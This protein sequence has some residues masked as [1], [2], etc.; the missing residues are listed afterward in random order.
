M[1]ASLESKFKIILNC[2]QKD[3][4]SQFFPHTSLGFH[5]LYVES[6]LDLASILPPAITLCH[7]LSGLVGSE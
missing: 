3:I 1:H 4:T 7:V 5:V 2:L 6:D